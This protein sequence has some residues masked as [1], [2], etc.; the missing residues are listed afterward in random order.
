MIC[1]FLLLGLPLQKNYISYRKS[2]T[3]L[4]LLSMITA[5]IYLRT[6]A[7]T[8][9]CIYHKSANFGDFPT[10]Q[11]NQPMTI[12]GLP[13]ITLVQKMFTSIHI[14]KLTIDKSP[15]CFHISKSI[16]YTRPTNN[17]CFLHISKRKNADTTLAVNCG[18]WGTRFLL[19]SASIC[20]LRS[21]LCQANHRACRFFFFC[22][23]GTW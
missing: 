14:F 8:Y 2:C 23:V 9:T 20:Y 5:P 6:N 22:K 15:R 17:T 21:D 3:Y 12:S 1:L 10:G 13:G 19:R 4:I 16:T 18:L 7:H 11:N